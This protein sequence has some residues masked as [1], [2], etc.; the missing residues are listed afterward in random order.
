M[1]MKFINRFVLCFLFIPMVCSTAIAQKGNPEKITGTVTFIT[2]LNI[3]VKFK[4][5]RGINQGDTLYA[6]MRG[7]AEPVLTAKYLS[8]QSLAGP[9]IGKV[10]LKVGDRVFALVIPPEQKTKSAQIAGEEVDTSLSTQAKEIRQT[11]VTTTNAPLT[12]NP[13]VYGG[14]TV[15]SYSNFSN[16]ANASDIQRWN[17]SLN[18][19]ADK[20]GGSHFYFSN[21]MY[22]SYL[23]SQ[24]KQ[25]AVS[26][27]GDLRVYDLALSYRTHDLN[28]WAGRHVNEDISGV[29]P[30][31]G[32]Q[33]E[34]RFGSVVTG[35][36]I[37][38]R[39]DFYS[40]GFNPNLFQFGGYLSQTVSMDAGT[41]RNTLGAFQQY[42]NL[43]T[44][45][46]FIYFQHN[47]TLFKILSLYASGQ[48]DI[49]KLSG[50][51][52]TNDFSLTNL[53]FSTAYFPFSQLSLNLSYSAQR[54]IIYYQTF[55]SALDSLL[56]RQ[57]Q[58]RNDARIEANIRPFPFTFITLGTGYS[59]QQGDVSPTRDA[60]ASLTQSNIPILLIT[61]GVSY[62]KILSNYLDGSVIGVSASK[63]IPLNSTDIMLMFSRLDYRFGSGT[64]RMIQDE[65]SFQLTTKL[66]GN[67]FLN[68]FYQ[69]TYSGKTSYGTFMG[70]I[71]ERF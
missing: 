35:E 4:D 16:F 9:I 49:F 20:I 3:Y 28:V 24:W 70:G 5:T 18:L 41:M 12:I 17:Y 43:N 23:G 29:G 62:S 68:L 54:N 44:D 64:M 42:N 51:N 45:R 33:A 36:V 53:Y 55:G 37:G 27:L 19:N 11:V 1:R 32:I 8:S 58:L 25:V 63:Y 2:P 48:V 46:R 57:N 56:E 34:E 13:R 22:M 50:G 65:P 60:N 69:G 61:L 14:F 40:L 38:Y 31:D 6:Y 67:L 39:P 59:F 66:L 7:K 21:Y 71:T 52:S 26:P 30:I 47:S 15:N 10:F